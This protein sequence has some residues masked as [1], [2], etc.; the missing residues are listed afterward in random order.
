MERVKVLAGLVRTLIEADPKGYIHGGE[1]PCGVV[2]DAARLMEEIEYRARA[3]GRV[4]G[5]RT[6]CD[7]PPVP[8]ADW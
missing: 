7:E 6:E 2:D 8:Y 3:L 1:F 5:H 4:R